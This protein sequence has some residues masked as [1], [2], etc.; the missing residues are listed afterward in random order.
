MV[1]NI[2]SKVYKFRCVNC[3]WSKDILLKNFPSSLFLS[4]NKT[5]NRCPKC[6]SK[7]QKENMYVKF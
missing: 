5:P 4:R 1:L 7:L 6:G 3:D 2:N